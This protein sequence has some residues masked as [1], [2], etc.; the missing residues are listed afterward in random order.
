M[1]GLLTRAYDRL[2]ARGAGEPGDPAPDPR[3]A[4][5]FFVLLTSYFLT[6]LGDAIT[7]PK[8]VLAW[9]GSS[10]GMPIYL[11][12]MLVPV[13][14]AGSLLPQ[15]YVAAIVRRQTIRKWLWVGG[16]CLQGLAI[17]AIAAVA[18]ALRGQAAGIAILAL[19]AIFAL[20]RSLSSVAAKDVLGKTIPKGQRGQVTGW[21]ASLA[22]LLTIG[23]GGTIAAGAGDDGSSGMLAAVLAGASLLWF[24]AAVT[25]ARIDEPRGSA[26][27]GADGEAS[28]WSRFRLLAEEPAFRDFIIVRALLLGSALT[29]PYLVILAQARIGSGA[30]VLGAFVAAGGL[31]SLVSAPAWGRLADR[32]ARAVMRIAALA[33]AAIG[34]AVAAVDWLWPAQS[35]S[36]WFLPL[37]F[38]LLSIAHAGARVGRKTYVVDLA[39]GNRR[40]DYVSIGNSVIGVLLLL[41]GLIGLAEPLLTIPGIILTFSIMGVASAAYGSRLPGVSKR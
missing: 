9:L 4:H 1:N 13:R 28:P 17:L 34:A 24:I 39:S 27:S 37:A 26:D 22:G 38:F 15:F 23:I 31:A 29:A 18:T 21:S 2:V 16:A 41:T 35:A 32:S 5:A 12:G 25:Y 10:I 7:N 8:T 3:T 20:A 36:G 6:K 19:T 11:V 40:T 30:Q 14:E 33:T